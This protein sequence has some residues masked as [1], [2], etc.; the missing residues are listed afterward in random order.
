M[1]SLSLCALAVSIVLMPLSV[2]IAVTDHNTRRADLERRLADDAESHAAALD[3]T[4]ARARTI[5]LITAHN[6]AFRELYT[7]PGDR[8]SKVRR[9]SPYVAAANSSLRYLESLFPRSIGELCFIDRSGAENARVVHGQAAPVGELSHDE[10][11]NPFFGPTFALR[12]GHVFQSRPYVS[13]DTHDWVVGNA[14]P[15]GVGRGAAPAIVH[16][17]LSI[18]SLRRDLI[19]SDG[20]FVL[21][22]IDA[23]SGRVIIDGSRPQRVGAPL[24]APSDHRFAHFARTAKNTG[25]AE[26]GGRTSAYRRLK[27]IDGNA[28]EWILVA[29]SAISTR[30]WLTGLGVLPGAMLALALVMLPFSVLS[31][32][33]ARR[34]LESAAATDSLTGLRN[35]RTLVADLERR[36]QRGADTP[37]CV[38]MLFD[39]DGFKG[40]NDSFGHLAGDA[41]LQRLGRTLSDAVAPHGRAY[42]LGGDE[43]CVLAD[44]AERTR[45]ELACALALSERG[46]G[47]EITAS[48]GTAL[49]PAEATNS[50]EALRI[51]DQRMYA[52]KTGGRATAGR[53]STDVL[54]RALAERHPDL[55]EHTDGVAALAR[56]VARLLQLPAEEVEQICHAA[57]L[58][59]IGKVAIPDAILT[60]P[61]PLND[62]EW[63]FMRRHTLIGERIVTAAPALA[64]VARL[65]RA[66]HE[67]W[68]GRGYPDGLAGEDIPLG[69]RIV[70]VCDAFD[71]IVS[72]RAYRPRRT[73]AE[74]LAELNRCTGTQ[75]DPAIVAAFCATLAEHGAPTAHA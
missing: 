31:L 42:R 65:V 37:A 19:H 2:G 11:G 9:G 8:R 15:L 75:F 72:D 3:A 73:I 57:E 18:E 4:F 24:G 58:H 26:V 12:P 59:D 27:H 14:T 23:A 38:L 55:G 36:L 22:V 47:F 29:S 45:V 71:A 70:A 61:G 56:D 5:T 10:A 1:R 21:R 6:A 46:E 48:F 32:R 54:L 40:Y 35:R 60:K 20:A 28:N 66:S 62:E 41:L 39:L 51:A 44:A 34:E 43:F 17:E 16:Y 7:R 53:Q 68:D 74:A 69:A 67:R 13:P 50:T 25:V 63:A 64:P 33:R 52:Q 30:S 49:L